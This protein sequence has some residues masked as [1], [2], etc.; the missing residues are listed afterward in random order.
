MSSDH[1][2]KYS[3][4]IKDV[5]IELKD[6]RF[7]HS[8]YEEQERSGKSNKTAG[9]AISDHTQE[10]FI[11]RN[12]VKDRIISILEYTD[13]KSGSYLITGFRGM[14]KT[15]VI[16]QAIGAFNKK[17]KR[18]SAFPSWWDRSISILLKCARIALIYAVV[19]IFL[20]RSFPPS[21]RPWI[22]IAIIL[23]IGLIHVLHTTLAHQKKRIDYLFLFPWNTFRIVIMLLLLFFSG[24]FFLNYQLL[25]PISGCDGT[26]WNLMRSFFPVIGPGDNAIL[27]SLIRIIISLVFSYLVLSAFLF[28]FDLISLITKK[29]FYLLFK[30]FRGKK[31]RDTQDREKKKYEPFEIYLSQDSLDEMD[32]LRRMTIAIEDYWLKEKYR[33]DSAIFDRKLYLPWRYLITKI[34]RPR[35]EGTGPSYTSVLTKLSSL[36][37]R[38]SGQVTTRK[39]LRFSPNFKTD[40]AGG[41][42]ELSMPM[43]TYSNNDEIV[44]PVANAKEAEHELKEILN[45]IDDLRSKPD[46]KIPQ[47]VFIIDELDKIEPNNA[48]LKGEP[49][50][51]VKDFNVFDP[52]TNRFRQR[53]EAVA[54]MLANLKGFLSVVKAKIFFIGGR[55]MFDADLADISD[56]ESFYSSIFNDVIY[57]ESFFKD[58]SDE[59]GRGKGGITQMTEAYVCRIILNDLIGQEDSGK[60]PN[61]RNLFELLY[62]DGNHLVF[63]D[64]EK[65]KPTTGENIKFGLRKLHIWSRNRVFRPWAKKRKAKKERFEED[66]TDVPKSKLRL[67][68]FCLKNPTWFIKWTNEKVYRLLKRKL[69]GQNDESKKQKYKVI[70]TLQNFI[71]FLTYRSNGTPKKL[72]G[73]TEQLIVRGPSGKHKK[74]VEDFYRENVV[75]LHKR[76]KG[77]K[78]E[79]IS[80]KLFLKFSF[81]TQYEIGLTSNLYRPYLIANSRH[82]KALGDKLLFS[83]SFII[84]HI[85][86]FHPFGFSWRNLELIPEVVLVNRE[87]NLREFIED[88]MRFYSLNYIRDTVSGIFDY[89]FRSIIR[90]ELIHLSKT[91]DLSSAAFNFTLDESLS[92][93]QHYKGKLVELQAKYK[94]YTPI[95][96]DNLFVHSLCFIQTILGD[97]HFYDKEYDEAILYYTESIQTLRLPDAVALRQITRHQFLLW[98]RNKLKLGLTLEKMRAFDSAFSLYKTLTLDTDRYFDKIVGKDEKSD[99]GNN[100][101]KRR[102]RVVRNLSTAASL[103][104]AEDHRTIQLVTMPFV[105]LLA[106]TEKARNDGITYTNLSTNRDDFLRTINALQK[107]K[108]TDFDPYRKNFL[109]ADYY[110]NV[111]SLLYYKNCQ[112]SNVFSTETKDKCFWLDAFEMVSRNPLIKVQEKLYKDG[113]RKPEISGYFPSLTSFNYYWNSLYFLLEYHIARI[114]VELK[115]ASG[116]QS[117]LWEK[118]KKV[119]LENNLLALTAGYLLPGCN[120]MISGSRLY[121]IANVVSKIGDSILASLSKDNIKLSED[122]FDAL[123][124]INSVDICYPEEGPSADDWK[125]RKQAR[126]DLILNM[127]KRLNELVNDK[128]FDVQT[129]L[130][131]Y[132]LAAVL[133]QK[134]GYNAYFASHLTRI[135]YVVKDVIELNKGQEEDPQNNSEN[136]KFGGLYAFWDVGENGSSTAAGPSPNEQ[137]YIKIQKIAEKVFQA[138][139]WNNEVS[140][141]PQILKYKEIFGL[142]GDQWD[143]DRNL[144]YNN[145]NNIPDT[146]EV[147]ILVEGIKMK[148]CKKDDFIN[149]FTLG[150]SITSAYG[151][152]NNRYQRMLELKYRMER[153]YFI[154]NTVLKLGFLFEPYEAISDASEGRTEGLKEWVDSMKDP[155]RKEKIIDDIG[156]IISYSGGKDKIEIRMVVEFLIQEA[157]FCSRQLINMIRL[158]NPGYVIGYSFIAAAHSRMGDWCQVYENYLQLTK[159]GASKQNENRS[160]TSFKEEIIKMLGTETLLYLE[161]KNHYET[162]LLFYHKMV[163]IHSDGKSYKDKLHDIYMLEDDYNDNAAHYTI[164]SERLRI[165]TG[166]TEIKIAKLNTKISDSMLYKYASYFSKE[167]QEAPGEVQ[168]PLQTESGGESYTGYIK[169]E[170]STFLNDS[171]PEHSPK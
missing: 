9:S 65:E 50:T 137:I 132:K 171:V 75:V 123:D 19:I 37:N 118:D 128:L 82:L 52:D 18:T 121:Y 87:P 157:L 35:E 28:S 106:V 27:S 7:F 138:T 100:Q 152:I 114:I 58:T 84:D 15:S 124:I 14:G 25:C 31:A 40:I 17:I 92:T 86:K 120:D 11:G 73:L 141:R 94:G 150:K 60:R 23:G 6:Y 160:I 36:R 3:A 170:F 12:K 156:K 163:Q 169:E 98:L 130:Y 167:D 22:S 166:D 24:I 110:N 51:P 56:R 41:L 83:S 164:A 133:Y 135:L 48:P 96:G 8:P 74:D 115:E 53:R 145:L 78:N 43:G 158:Y 144:I 57:V 2:S 140:N 80:E 93:K 29:I 79:D 116:G 146:K 105:A 72:T 71:I 155:V 95:T 26:V 153:C 54:R 139:T 33:F 46:S 134:A 5:Y 112:F 34:D 99:Q 69:Q 113:N 107:G 77:S 38:M 32:V 66:R 117:E 90:R 161:P 151:S 148:L 131:I 102:G 122:N 49:D 61:L 91:S 142:S 30:V 89:R 67:I 125:N 103:R 76:E 126:T 10:R 109:Q 21:E 13:I 168:E 127:I 39:E 136:D 55:E 108:E 162:A 143:L 68:V 149:K 62:R 42:A 4:K 59:S 165:N 63:K 104:E 85:L 64:P 119:K 44:F 45:D 147:M 88:L 101:H 159:V 81:N 16:R 111:G 97:L 129:V 70:F 1:L 47:F 20:F 154:L